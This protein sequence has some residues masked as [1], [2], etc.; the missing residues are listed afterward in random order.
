[1]FALH[2]VKT[3]LLRLS[4]MCTRS[5][6]YLACIYRV[7]R[8]YGDINNLRYSSLNHRIDS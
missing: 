1:M 4:S 7:L 3:H 8:T 2:Y 5:I 6:L